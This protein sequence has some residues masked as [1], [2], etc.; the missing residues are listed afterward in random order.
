MLTLY[1]DFLEEVDDPLVAEWTFS[2]E[3]GNVIFASAIDCWGFGIAKFSQ[4]WSQ[5]LGINRNVLRKH[6]FED[7]SYNSKTKKFVKCQIGTDPLFATMILDPIWK[8]YDASVTQNN[9][10]KAAK[11]A[12]RGV[13][14][15]N[16]KSCIF[17]L[18]P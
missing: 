8:L 11:M 5:K 18:T 16:F 14:F 4:I 17:M 9:P 3:S 15:L 7:Y 2:P 1:L 12:E 10:E 6:L 13:R